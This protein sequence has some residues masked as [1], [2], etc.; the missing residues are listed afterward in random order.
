[1]R[2]PEQGQ[3]L[4]H[5]H[6]VVEAIH[7]GTYPRLTTQNVKQ[8]DRILDRL[9]SWIGRVHHVDFTLQAFL[10]I[11]SGG[12]CNTPRKA[13]APANQAESMQTLTPISQGQAVKRISNS[14]TH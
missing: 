9:L 1:M 11:I 12:V 2:G 6:D 4:I 10:K 14:N 13:I 3:I 5:V 8:G 7:Q